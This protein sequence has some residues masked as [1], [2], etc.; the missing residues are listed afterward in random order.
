MLISN[1]IVTRNISAERFAEYK[2]KGYVEVKTPEEKK[3]VKKAKEK[4]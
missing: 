1:G 4:A 2:S 3:P